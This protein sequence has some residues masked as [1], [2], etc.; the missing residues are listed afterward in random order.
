MNIDGVMI[1]PLKKIFNEKGNIY[2]C[3]KNSDPGF[4][5]FGEAYFSSVTCG[6]VKGWNRHKN[7]TLNLIVAVGEV[8]FVICEHIK[9]HRSKSKFFQ[10]T[11]S[12][13][14][15]HRLTIPPGLWVA[16]QGKGSNLNLILNI[17]DSCHDTD[18][19]EKVELDIFPY[20]F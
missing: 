8:S 18:E 6:A 15:Y 7:M 5:G 4:M 3:L 11:L 2:H 9:E 20:K 19:L 1:T 14:N 16:F 10:I 12:E 17:A 13:S